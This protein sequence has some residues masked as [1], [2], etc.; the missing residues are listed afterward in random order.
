[1]EQSRVLITGASSG[2][3]AALAA[4]L[5]SHHTVMLTGRAAER[6]ASVV[7]T[8]PTGASAASLA[9]D[10]AE[11]AFRERLVD[12]AVREL[13][14]L[15]VVINCAG[16]GATGYFDVD[17]PLH[18]RAMLELNLLAPIE[19]V[20]KALPAL[21]RS[22]HPMIVNIASIAGRRGI[23]GYSD[24]CATKFALCGWTEAVRAELAPFGIHMLLVCPGP[25]ATAAN[26]NF[27]EDRL[28]VGEMKIREMSAETCAAHIVRAMSA[29]RNELVLS[30]GGRILLLLNRWLPRLVDRMLALKTR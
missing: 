10:I 16:V 6:L 25:T 12:T 8:L 19:L 4:A 24:Y 15:D 3:G 18:L 22:T 5:A 17:G 20:R 2:I 1:M 11:A 26:A 21:R 23:P 29:R 14:G 7:A 13:G 30:S 27:L 9:G 28:K